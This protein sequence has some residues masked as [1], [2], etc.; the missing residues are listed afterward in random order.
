MTM[1]SPL[2]FRTLDLN[3]LRVFDVVMDERN[4]TRAAARLSIT[5]PAVSNALKRLKDSVGADLFTRTPSGVN[6]TPRAQALW[7]QVRA[8]LGQLRAAL[9]PGEFNPQTDAVNFRITMADAAAASFMP[10]LVAQI[11]QARALANLRLLPLT[12]RDPSRLL[13]RGEAD[14]AVGHFPE[15]VTALGADGAEAT[16]RHQPLQTSDYVCVMRKGH[17]LATGPLTLDRYCAAHH[18]LVSFSGR[19][20]GRT[21][22]A[23]SALNRARRVVLVVNQYFSAG[24]VVASSDLLT[25]LPLSFMSATGF[26][27]RVLARP[28]PFDLD[29]LNVTMLW[30]VRHDRVSSHAWLRAR[31]IEAAGADAG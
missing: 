22:A 6:P 14:L 11:E 24:R 19:A 27:D 21:D 31:L 12:T 15:A 20:T 30:H 2:N 10:R 25:V 18:L 29:P 3:L 7:P 16:L 5:Q 28:L 4:L 13:E 8:A 26:Q 23:L 9:A 1:P 17:P